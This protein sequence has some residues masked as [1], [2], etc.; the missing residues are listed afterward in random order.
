M[1]MMRH[2]ARAVSVSTDLNE[3]SHQAVMLTGVLAYGLASR[4]TH[5]GTAAQW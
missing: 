5:V 1:R 4:R 3:G 2:N